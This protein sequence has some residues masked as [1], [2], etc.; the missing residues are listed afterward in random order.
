MQ[1]C[2]ATTRYTL[3]KLREMDWPSWANPCSN[4]VV[5]R[6]P[7]DH[8]IKRWQLATEKDISHLI[9]MPGV[10]HEMIDSFVDELKKERHG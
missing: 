6:R 9:L 4:I 10:T 3:E 1:Q 2:F 7:S 8:L 5:I